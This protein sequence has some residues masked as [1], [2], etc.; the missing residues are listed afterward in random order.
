MKNTAT[1]LKNTLEGVNSRLDEAEDR[2]IDLED[3]VVENTQSEQKTIK[4]NRMRIGSG[5]SGTTSS[6]PTFAS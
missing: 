1:V 4:N 2:I 5:T 3:K 6:I